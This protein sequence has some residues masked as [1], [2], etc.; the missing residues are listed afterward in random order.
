MLMA[1]KGRY[2]NGRFILP[3]LEKASIPDNVN[4]IITILDEVS[5][6]TQAKPASAT[7]VA[8]R[9]FLRAMQDLRK[10]GFAEEDEAAIIDLQNGSYKPSFEERL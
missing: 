10:N 6:G 9:N 5:L 1:Y 4:I 7:Q 3:E 8:A 2:E